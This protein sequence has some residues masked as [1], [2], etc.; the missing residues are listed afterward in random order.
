[1]KHKYFFNKGIRIINVGGKIYF[2]NFKT[3]EEFF[4]HKKYYNLL[5]KINNG[6][7][8][9]LFLKKL[10]KN[11]KRLLNEFQKLKIII[12]NN[13][14]SERIKMEDVR[15][16]QL[17]NLH[18]EITGK[19]NLN[20]L[21]CYEGKKE[22]KDMSIKT[23]K[24]L[25]KQ[26][27][28]MG[29]RRIRISG[30][31]PFIH[32]KI[33]K[34]ID[35]INKKKI[36]ISNII[37]NGILLSRN[38]KVLK[39]LKY[40]ITVTVSIDGIEPKTVMVRG[41]DPKECKKY[42][43]TIESNIFKLKKIGSKIR[44][45]TVINGINLFHLSNMHYYFKKLPID[46]WTISIPKIKGNFEKNIK[47]LNFSL[48]DFVIES[49]KLIKIYKKETKNNKNLFHLIIP[50]VFD[51]SLPKKS[52]IFTTK[53]YICSYNEN[54]EMCCIKP[55]GKVTFCTI[56][57]DINFG[58]IN[59]VSLQRIWNSKKMQ[60]MKLLRIEDLEGCSKCKMIP[61]CGGGCRVNSYCKYK[62]FKCKDPIACKVMKYTNKLR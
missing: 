22:R 15:G 17:K 59:K 32:P 34:V 23:I 56:F 21:H 12:I 1:M 49:K 20:C 14:N 27:E 48:E 9:N 40:P 10:E 26:T 42:M 36:R 13:K 11:E 55:N 24:S 53:N 38:I 28:K 41:I 52:K 33:T 62:N 30:G 4:V 44:V 5:K 37:T 43:D 19:C 2:F 51:S 8:S 16:R 18:L 58:N 7:C 35:L 25:L 60:K 45:N 39:N 57:D 47:L 3:N 29:I 6:I 54:N 50:W 46:E 61:F 31:E